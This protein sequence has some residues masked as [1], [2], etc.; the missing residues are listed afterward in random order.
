MIK[1]IRFK[2]SLNKQLKAAEIQIELIKAIR[3]YEDA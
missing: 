1:D 3:N 2:L